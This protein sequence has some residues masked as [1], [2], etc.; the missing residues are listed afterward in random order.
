MPF[1]EE[2][3]RRAPSEIGYRTLLAEACLREGAITRAIEILASSLDANAKPRTIYVLALALLAVERNGEAKSAATEVIRLN[4][5]MDRA[6][7]V[8]A[9]AR[10]MQGD[11]EGALDDLRAATH[12][13]RES[14]YAL[15]FARI[16][17]EAARDAA[18]VA[19]PE[20]LRTALRLVDEGG[21]ADAFSRERQHLGG[22]L[23]FALNQPAE[24]IDRIHVHDPASEP[25]LALLRGY[26]LLAAGRGAEATS[27]LRAARDLPAT[28]TAATRY[29]TAFRER[30][31]MAPSLGEALLAAGEPAWPELRTI[32]A[33]LVL[34]PAESWP[35]KPEPRG[36]ADGD[37]IDL[38]FDGDAA[39][40]SK[41]PGS[42]TEVSLGRARALLAE[43]RHDA[44]VRELEHAWEQVRPGASP[45]P[46][47][48]PVPRRVLQ[49][50]AEA[51]AAAYDQ[52]FDGDVAPRRVRE[53]E[54]YAAGARYPALLRSL[55]R[56][57]TSHEPR[58]D[59]FALDV[60]VTALET[61]DVLAADASREVL[62][63]LTASLR[64]DLEDD[65]TA[66][67]LRVQLLERLHRVRPGLAFPRLYLGRHAVTRG[68][69][70][71]ALAFLGGLA[72]PLANS[73]QV[74]L[75]RGQCLESFGDLDRALALYR[76]AHARAPQLP[77]VSYRIGRVLLRF[78]AY[79]APAGA[80]R[81]PAQAD[82]SSA[83]ESDSEG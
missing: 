6:F 80:E 61:P 7:F 72:G 68:D 83:R 9:L 50:L 21:G 53:E 20:V 65:P 11:L 26:A 58:E 81:P 62:K 73:A 36:A 66:V 16:A 18:P 51:M 12:A 28:R 33:K 34:P 1:L 60:L 82:P 3:V 75:L 30:G 17:I 2:A 10:R 39:P 27:D 78:G 15:A 5:L 49:T 25:R 74:L 31:R 23:A 55:V 19:T 71:R 29:L 45:L 46:A 64:L 59:A 69:P 40:Q 52:S 24:A 13:R 35:F 63:A 48:D 67:E 4:P 43:G 47:S 14:E 54:L 8:R 76:E 42:D 32:V 56:K 77:E 70:E 22:L 38:E 79:A 37:L 41:A 57:Y 44:A